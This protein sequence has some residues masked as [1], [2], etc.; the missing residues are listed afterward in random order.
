LNAGKEVTSNDHDAEVNE[1]IVNL[2][3]SM[4]MN[5]WAPNKEMG[6]DVKIKESVERQI[7]QSKTL[8]YPSRCGQGH[9]FGEKHR[10]INH[11]PEA[12]ESNILLEQELEI[13][14]DTKEK[15]LIVMLMIRIQVK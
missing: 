7:N 6:F 13:D 12:E 5:L 15:A 3:S 14:H 4:N 2:D 10:S 11:I 9:R 1:E 8:H